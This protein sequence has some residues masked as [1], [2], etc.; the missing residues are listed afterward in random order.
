[1]KKKVNWFYGSVCF[2]MT[3]LKKQDTVPVTLTYDRI[4]KY[5]PDTQIHTQTD[6]VKTIPRNPLRGR[7]NTFFIYVPQCEKNKIFGYLVIHVH[8]EAI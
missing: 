1:M 7:G 6:R 8:M 2:D 3:T 4:T 5:W